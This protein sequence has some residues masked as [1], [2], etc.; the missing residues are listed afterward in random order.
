MLYPPLFANLT[1][2]LVVH[3]KFDGDY[4]DSSGRANDATAF[5]LPIL[6][7]GR[8]GQGVE[9]KTDK[10]ARI[11]NYLAVY[12]PNSDFQFGPSDSFSIAVWLKYTNSFTDLPILGNAGN[13]TYNPGYVLTEDANQFEW[14]AIG[15]QNVGQITADPVG[16]PILNDGAWHHLAVV[17]DRSAAVARSF[18]DG[19][20]I[21]SRPIGGLG[22][23]ITG[24]PLTIGQ[25][26]TGA[27][28]NNGTFDLDDL[29]VWRRALTPTEAAAIY[30]VGQQNVSFDTFGPVLLTIRTAGNDLELAWQTGTLLSSTTGVQGTYSPVPGASAPYYRVAPGPTPTFYR[31]RF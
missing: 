17:F 21:D 4:T 22:S 23:L 18:V 26:P 6:V 29:G 12:D 9:V 30:M 11:F 24:N 15:V 7:P 3:L 25:D 28:P 16:G 2:G 31:V 19:V 27:Y 14:T 1:N 5:G 10:D 8:L 13:S 20:A